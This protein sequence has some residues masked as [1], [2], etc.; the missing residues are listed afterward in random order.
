MFLKRT[1]RIK[2]GK[3]H[4]Y[5]SVV[6]NRRLINGK[7][8]QRQVL[9]LCEINDSQKLAW[10]KSIEVF[11]EGTR[12]QV[13]LFADDAL[14]A[15]DAR[16]IGV[17]LSEMQLK[18]PRQWGACWLS[19]V[20]WQ[21]LGMDEFWSARLLASRKGTRW[22]QVLQTLVAYRLIDPGSEWRLH[23]HCFT[24]SAMA[25]LL[26]ADFALAGKDTLYRCLDKLLPH[27]DALM[28]FLKQRWG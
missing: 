15:D 25:D 20:L 8:M 19:C 21:Q 24:S 17:R 14:P 23:R 13:A 12:R 16:A 10:R 5:W 28:L 2:D 18:R 4:H 7:V 6:E 1:R 9:Y 26:D 27:K 3:T 22:L 11:D